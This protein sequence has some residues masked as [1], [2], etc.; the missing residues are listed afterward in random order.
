MPQLFYFFWGVGSGG[1]QQSRFTKYSCLGCGWEGGTQLSITR[2]RAALLSQD[3][4]DTPPTAAR[5]AGFAQTAHQSSR[6]GWRLL[7]SIMPLFREWPWRVEWW[8]LL[9]SS[10]PSAHQRASVWKL[11]E[12]GGTGGVEAFCSCRWRTLLAT[13]EGQ[14]LPRTPIC[15]LLSEKSNATWTSKCITYS[16]TWIG[17]LRIWYEWATSRARESITTEHERDVG[18]DAGRQSRRLMTVGPCGETH[19]PPSVQGV[20]RNGSSCPE[21]WTLVTSLPFYTY[22]PLSVSASQCKHRF[23]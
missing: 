21:Y 2:I 4:Q 5:Q 23:L 9:W 7:H 20:P 22:L 14:E 17:F 13:Q 16:P 1:R 6:R 12:Q 3:R 11:N 19:L 15:R 18:R 10:T 8:H